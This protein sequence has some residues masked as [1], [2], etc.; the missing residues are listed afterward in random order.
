MLFLVNIDIEC[1][2]PLRP[3]AAIARTHAIPSRNCSQAVPHA[4][5]GGSTRTHGDLGIVR[6]WRSD[7][8]PTDISRRM[9][10]GS[11]VRTPDA[12]VTVSPPGQGT[13]TFGHGESPST[14]IGY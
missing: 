14:G 4:A 12:V 6:Y 13:A 1:C 11:T 10:D 9:G 5:R 7:D 2:R 8:V 3:I